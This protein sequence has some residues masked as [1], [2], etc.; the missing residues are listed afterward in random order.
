[1]HY[2]IENSVREVRLRSEQVRKRRENRALGWFSLG[3]CSILLILTLAATSAPKLP[4][5]SEG[6]AATGS[7]LLSP[8]AGGYILAIVVAFA[9]GVTVTLLALQ[10]K[11]T[12]P[13]E[14]QTPQTN[15]VEETT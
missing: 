2:T 7:F 14:E 4:P 15:D 11:R 9:L 8:E 10:R 1:M 5:G 13:P 6:S 12:K 3:I